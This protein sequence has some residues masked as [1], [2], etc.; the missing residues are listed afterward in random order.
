MNDTATVKIFLV[1]G[2]PA[3][4]KTAEISNWS[5]K[6]VSG[7]RSQLEIVLQREEAAKPGVYFLTGINP[8]TGKE[9]VYI[10]E[11]EIIRSRIK[12]HLE[13][14]FWKMISFFVSKDEN[15][16]KAHIK[17][18]EGQL[19]ERV[20][21]AGRYEL[22]NTNSSGSHLPESDSADMDVFLARMEQLLP[23]LGQDFLKPISKPEKKAVKLDLLYCQ[24]KN[25]R[26]TGK[27]TE[28]GFVV[29]ASSAAV[30]E[31]RPSTQKYP[32][33]AILR[34]QLLSEGV[35]VKANDRL[36]FKQD[37]EFS[38]PSAAASVIHGGHANGLREWK[39]SN[40]VQLKD[41]EE[42]GL[43]SKAAPPNGGPAM[44]VGDSQVTGG[45]PS[46]S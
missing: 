20:K 14:D 24:I 3:S 13:R 18:L 42:K 46:V 28:N 21:T 8:A 34:S 4:V 44:S 43:S 26:A 11:A 31:D 12:G 1:Q 39:D 29:L 25:V 17:Y 45:R 32:Y 41:K 33:P 40:G 37:Y 6:A 15:L 9:R 35:L 7:P 10:G 5:G 16:T 19:I 2:D 30:L 36:V 38:S 22:E 27:Q 23:L